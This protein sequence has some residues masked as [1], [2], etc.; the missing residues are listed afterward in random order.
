MDTDLDVCDCWERQTMYHV[1]TC[2]D[3]PNCTWTDMAI[4]DTSHNGEN[5]EQ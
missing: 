4:P 1:M 3:A 5:V 2:G